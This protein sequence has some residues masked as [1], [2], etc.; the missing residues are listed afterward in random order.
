MNRPHRR[1]TPLLV[2]IAV[3]LEMIDGE[4]A[5][6]LLRAHATAPERKLTDLMIESDLVS[7]VWD[8]RV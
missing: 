1:S 5:E 6:G 7:N 2:R 4:Q 8:W 3:Q